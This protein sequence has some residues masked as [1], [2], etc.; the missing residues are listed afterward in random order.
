MLFIFPL[1]LI[2]GEYSAE[3]E[4]CKKANIDKFLRIWINE[5]YDITINDIKKYSTGHTENKLIKK[6]LLKA[7]ALDSQIFSRYLKRITVRPGVRSSSDL[8]F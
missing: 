3:D 1:F 8:I 7:E 5:A 2:A 6:F 4:Q